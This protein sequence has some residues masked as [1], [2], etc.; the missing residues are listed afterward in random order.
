M[1]DDMSRALS[2]EVA[3]GDIGVGMSPRFAQALRAELVDATNNS[4]TATRAAGQR[5]RRWPWRVGGAVTVLAVCGTAYALSSILP[6]G[7]EVTGLS[8]PVVA[9]YTGSAVI[10][11]G[12]RPGDATGVE[13]G[14]RC[15]GAGTIQFPDGSRS[16]CDRAE[17]MAPGGGFPGGLRV[18]LAPG[19]DSIR[20][21]ASPSARWEA[22]ARYV[23][24]RVTSWEVNANGDTY[25]VMNYQGE[26][27]LQAVVATNGQLGYAYTR[28][29][30]AAGGPPPRNPQ[31]AATRTP[32][33]VSIPVYQSDGKTVVGSFIVGGGGDPVRDSRDTP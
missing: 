27:D 16:E 31:E 26:P 17:P 21:E 2:H 9:T 24:E 14:F 12:A 3:D 18:P 15:L 29:L 20:I 22:S 30:N 4:S 13:I 32:G 10:E 11:L 5:M 28:D 7:T 25:G 19:Q 33:S 8:T 6:G 1:T 23:N